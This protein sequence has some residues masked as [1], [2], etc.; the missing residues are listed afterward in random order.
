M[1]K[2]NKRQVEFYKKD[3]KKDITCRQQEVL[4]Q[5][6]NQENCHLVRCHVC[7]NVLGTKTKLFGKVVRE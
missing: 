3:G 4:E 5:K 2:N 6:T 7:L 1:A